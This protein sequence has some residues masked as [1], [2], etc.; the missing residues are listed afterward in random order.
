[1][2][3]ARSVFMI[4]VCNNIENAPP[5]NWNGALSCFVTFC[6]MNGLSQAHVLLS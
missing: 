2:M 3:V 5:Q 4:N 6:R 1:M